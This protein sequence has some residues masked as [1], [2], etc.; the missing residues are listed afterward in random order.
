MRNIDIFFK[1]EGVQNTKVFLLGIIQKKNNLNKN[2][3]D[4]I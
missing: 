3:Q 4:S 1:I 2:F